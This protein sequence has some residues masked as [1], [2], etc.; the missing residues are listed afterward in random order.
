MIYLITGLNLVLNTITQFPKISQNRYCFIYTFTSDYYS[1]RQSKNKYSIFSWCLL[2]MKWLHR[3]HFD[4]SFL[5]C[6]FLASL[7]E[8]LSIK[9]LAW[10]RI[11]LYRIFGMTEDFS[12]SNVNWKLLKE[13]Y[14]K[15]RHYITAKNVLSLVWVVPKMKT[16]APK[17]HLFNFIRLNG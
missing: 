13:S 16:K 14:I 6:F 15:K 2:Q 7:Y 9:F 12:S 11:L 3:T 5:F 1:Q 17:G 10:I 4:F 8:Y